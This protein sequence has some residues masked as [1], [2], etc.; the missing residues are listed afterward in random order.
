MKEMIGIV[1][2][3]GASFLIGILLEHLEERK[4]TQETERVHMMFKH[5]SKSKSRSETDA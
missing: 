5:M 1:I 4:R 2:V 3:F